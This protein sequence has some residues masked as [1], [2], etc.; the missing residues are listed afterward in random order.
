MSVSLAVLVVC[1]VCG[2]NVGWKDQLGD[3]GEKDTYG[4]G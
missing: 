1:L 2:G 4:T 3:D